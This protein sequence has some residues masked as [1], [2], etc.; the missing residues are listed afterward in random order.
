[1]GV[2]WI[3]LLG[4]VL[5]FVG[6][7]A[8]ETY[9]ALGFLATFAIAAIVIVIFGKRQQRKAKQRLATLARAVQNDQEAL[10]EITRDR[11]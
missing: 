6:A 7:G 2:L 4:F 3:L 11:F 5:I 9:G 10:R 8:T 1:M